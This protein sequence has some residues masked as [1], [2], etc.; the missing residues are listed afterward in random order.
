M[1]H[2]VYYFMFD[3][4][5]SSRKVN[6]STAVRVWNVYPALRAVLIRGLCFTTC[7][8]RDGFICTLCA[9]NNYRLCEFQKK[10]T[11]VHAKGHARDLIGFNGVYR[12]E[13]ILDRNVGGS[14]WGG[15]GL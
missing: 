14:V 10:Y 3:T 1:I 5:C 6:C 2:A 15:Y 4:Q 13:N 12:L 9:N 7:I 11:Q 8:C